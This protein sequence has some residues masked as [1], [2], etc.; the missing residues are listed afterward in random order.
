MWPNTTNPTAQ[1]R[2]NQ[3]INDMNDAVKVGLAGV[4]GIIGLMALSYFGLHWSG[5]LGAEREAIRTSIIKNSQAYTDGKRNELNRLYLE[6]QKA[7][8]AG[9]IGISNATRDMFAAVDTS[10]Y[11]AHLQQCL[12]T[13]GAK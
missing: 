2:N 4:G 10:G 1:R 13:T 9:R 5:F 11:P 3:G 6:Y 8:G 7:D 12:S